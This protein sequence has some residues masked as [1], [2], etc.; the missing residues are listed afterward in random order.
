MVDLIVSVKKAVT[1]ET[2]NILLMALTFSD[3][4]TFVSVFRVEGLS[5]SV[6]IFK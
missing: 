1:S 6:N 2:Q 5:Y 3:I 4:P